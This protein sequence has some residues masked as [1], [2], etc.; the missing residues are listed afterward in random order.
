MLSAG[1]FQFAVNNKA[2][3]NSM[4]NTKQIDQIMDKIDESL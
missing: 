3:G 1:L 2:G 4:E